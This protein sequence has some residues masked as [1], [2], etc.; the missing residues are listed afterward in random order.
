MA[1]FNSK[2]LNYQRDTHITYWLPDLI[3]PP[4]GVLQR[5]LQRAAHL[6]LGGKKGGPRWIKP[7]KI[8]MDKGL[9]M[10]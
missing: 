9:D 2:L 1:M 5:P 6:G 3:A 4:P 10:I 7:G 8:E